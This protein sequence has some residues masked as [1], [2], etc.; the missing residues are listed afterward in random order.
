MAIHQPNGVSLLDDVP[1]ELAGLIIFSGDR[2]DFLTSELAGQV[3]KLLLCLGEF[4]KYFIIMI[5][6][7]W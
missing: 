3:L 7:V 4:C 5:G 6:I 1:W 2:D